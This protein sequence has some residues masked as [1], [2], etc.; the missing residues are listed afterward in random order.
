MQAQA[1]LQ[2][3]LICDY[4]IKYETETLSSIS[5]GI[6]FLVKSHGELIIREKQLG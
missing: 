2:S 6:F 1:K 4:E 3:K 5:W